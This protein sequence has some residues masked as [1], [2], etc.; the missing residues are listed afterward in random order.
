MI[1]WLAVRLRLTHL[2]G[3]R[4]FND[5]TVCPGDNL[6][7][8]LG[9]LAV[10]AGLALGT[11]GYLPPADPQAVPEDDATTWKPSPHFSC[12]HCLG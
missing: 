2:A 3:H 4:D 9:T 11:K 1:N 6:Y 12:S 7:E 8:L 5:I 10:R